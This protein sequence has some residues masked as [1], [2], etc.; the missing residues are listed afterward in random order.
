MKKKR[1]FFINENIS[2]QI[3]KAYGFRV[4]KMN[5]YQLR[6][7]PQETKK[8]YDWYHTQG[9]VVR[10]ED[11]FPSRFGTYGDAEKLAEA[12]RKDIK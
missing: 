6:L 12:I 10:N 9:S 2:V 8:T 4:V 1:K 3:L 11:H 5:W 7:A